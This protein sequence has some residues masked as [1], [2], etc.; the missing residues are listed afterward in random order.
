MERFIELFTDLLQ[1]FSKSS[2]AF[3]FTGFFLIFGLTWGLYFNTLEAE[4][5]FDDYDYIVNMPNKD[6]DL[7]IRN[8][9][10][11]LSKLFENFYLPGKRFFYLTLALNYRFHE[12]DLPSYH[13]INILIHA[14]NGCLVFMLGQLLFKRFYGLKNHTKI[15]VTELER[16]QT[17]IISL[18]GERRILALALSL[19]F[20]AHPLAVNSITYI[21]QRSGALATLFYLAAFSAYLCFKSVEHKWRWGWLAGAIILYWFALQSKSMAMTLPLVIL[22]YELVENVDHPLIFWRWVKVAIAGALCF[23][24]AA[25]LYTYKIHMFSPH[26]LDVGFNSPGLWSPWI[27]F[28]TEVRVFVRYWLLLA[29][30]WPGWLSVNHEVPLSQSLLEIEVLGSL[31]FHVTLLVG[32][33]WCIKK[34]YRLAGFGVFWF[35]LTMSPPYL[36]LPQKEVMVEYKTYL[37][38]V[39]YWLIVGELL[40]QS[41]N[42]IK[43]I[44]KIVGIG[45][46]LVLLGGTTIARNSVFQTGEALWSDVLEKYP[47]SMRAYD[48]RGK[49]YTAAGEYQKALQDYTSALEINAGYVSGYHNRGNVYFK[50]QQYENAL[51]DYNRTVILL[52]TLPE[53]IQS[54]YRYALVYYRRGRTWMKLQQ[55]ENAVRDFNQYLKWHSDDVLSY[56]NRARA[57]IELGD[58][59]SA[60]QDY[61]QAIQFDPEN[62]QIYTNRGNVYLLLKQFKRAIQD[63]NQALLLDAN[64]VL[65]YINRGHAFFYLKQYELAIQSYDKALQLQPGNPNISRLRKNALILMQG[66]QHK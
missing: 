10:Q 25:L 22:C 20:I 12:L 16:K 4:F 28:L 66:V 64:H 29:L 26:S 37:P 50:L 42:W 38:S 55:Y 27:H 30:P 62:V 1:K 36:V 3:L 34:G 49:A 45:V 57:Y 14:I 24:G 15:T 65:T 19:L 5:H 17:P 44:Y 11:S 63:Y 46:V 58:H 39:G 2:W 35:Y 59:Q 40:F 48:N 60:L 56:M 6:F 54:K 41:R 23:L 51:A 9:D 33:C 61:E 47:N 18:W 53:T 31:F 43:W 13:Q 7:D 21:T 8:F 32:A 52:Q